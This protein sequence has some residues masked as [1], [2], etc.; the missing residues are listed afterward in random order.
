ML[1]FPKYPHW[2]RSFKGGRLAV[3]KWV[4]IAI[5]WAADAHLGWLA[6][7][8]GRW[9]CRNDLERQRELVIEV[10]RRKFDHE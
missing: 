4:A 5:V 6:Q 2:S 9:Y 7:G 10:N 3:K 8:L 1:I